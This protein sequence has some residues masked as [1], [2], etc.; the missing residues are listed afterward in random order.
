[1][2][3]TTRAA[4]GTEAVMLGEKLGMTSR[5]HKTITPS[6]F[7]CRKDRSNVLQHTKSTKRQGFTNTRWTNGTRRVKLKWLERQANATPNHVLIHTTALAAWSAAYPV[8]LGSSVLGSTKETETCTS[9]ACSFSSTSFVYCRDV[10]TFCQNKFNRVFFLYSIFA[11][12]ICR[13][14]A[15]WTHTRRGLNMN[16]YDEAGM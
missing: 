16:V 6:T 13:P 11:A 7:R 8:H 5:A 2:K 14:F 12:C 1:M 15:D 3:S 9:F 4:L 10:R